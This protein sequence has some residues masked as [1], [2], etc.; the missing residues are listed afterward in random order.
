MTY[1]RNKPRNR[2]KEQT[3]DALV[4]MFST[5]FAGAASFAVAAFIQSFWL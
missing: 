4:I 3:I 1:E 5:A 2:R